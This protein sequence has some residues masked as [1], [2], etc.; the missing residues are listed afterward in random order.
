MVG[1]QLPRK[2]LEGDREA[3][4]NN[5]WFCVQQTIPGLPGAPGVPGCPGVPGGPGRPAI[6]NITLYSFYQA[7]W[8]AG[9]TARLA[10]TFVCFTFRS[11]LKMGN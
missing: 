1:F 5:N 4:D 2:L 9:N 6:E 3:L 7:T 10:T 8:M 11:M